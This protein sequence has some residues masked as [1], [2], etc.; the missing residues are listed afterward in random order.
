MNDDSTSGWSAIELSAR[1]ALARLGLKVDDEA[2]GSVKVAG[3]GWTLAARSA[4][5]L[6]RDML[7][8]ASR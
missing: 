5:E 3:D 1:A 7:P 8:G 4:R 2:D 6:L